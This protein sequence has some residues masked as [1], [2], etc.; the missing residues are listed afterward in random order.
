MCAV[1]H[2]AFIIILKN[3]PYYHIHF[4]L[5][6]ALCIVF[7]LWMAH[8]WYNQCLFD[9]YLGCF[10]M[11]SDSDAVGIVVHV[12]SSTFISLTMV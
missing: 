12:I 5:L 4:C 10:Q 9:R 7:I 11:A 6:I 3:F 1:L 2:L 8:D